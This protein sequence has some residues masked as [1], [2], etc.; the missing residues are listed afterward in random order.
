M[1]HNALDKAQYALPGHTCNNA[2]L[3]KTLFLDLSR[4]TLTPGILTDYDATAAFDRVLTGLSIITCQCVGLPCIAGNFMFHLLKHMSFHLIT[5]FGQSNNSFCNTTYGLTGQGI[6][7][8]SSSAAPLFLLNSDISL[9]TYWKLSKGATFYHPI[10]KNLIYDQTVHFIDDTSQF[11]N[12]TGV[13]IENSSTTE[14]IGPYLLPIAS[15]NSQI[16]ADLQVA[17]WI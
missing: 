2:V 11:L 1:Q 14:T 8:G 13:N 3:N 15:Q 9:S 7:Q 5:G 17:I 4:Q 12:P 10:T 16:W 6:L